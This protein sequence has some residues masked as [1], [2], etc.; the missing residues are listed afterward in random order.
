MVPYIFYEPFY[1]ELERLL[2]DPSLWKQDRKA[3]SCDVAPSTPVV[4]SFKPR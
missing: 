2:N 1:S 3:G 4:K